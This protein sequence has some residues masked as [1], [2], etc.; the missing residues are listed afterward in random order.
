ITCQGSLTAP[1]INATK[2]ICNNFEP[3]TVNTDMIISANRVLL[4]D[5]IPHTLLSGAVSHFYSTAEFHNI[6]YFGDN[7]EAGYRDAND[8][9][10]TRFFFIHKNGNA[11]THGNFDVASLLTAPNIYNK[12]QVENLLSGK[13]EHPNIQRP[14]AIKSTRSGLSIIRRR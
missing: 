5:T 1:T 12:N 4:G 2:N 14:H 7:V 10:V 8:M 3:T 11:Y 6:V 13:A 9:F